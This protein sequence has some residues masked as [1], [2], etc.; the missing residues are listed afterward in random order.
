MVGG[1][2]HKRFL[3]AALA[4]HF[5]LRNV[6]FC[7]SFTA[8]RVASTLTTRIGRRKNAY[9]SPRS[10]S[11]G[12]TYPR[13]SSASSTALE[14]LPPIEQVVELDLVARGL[15]YVVGAGSLVL[16]TPIAVRL[17]RQGTA[18][19]LTMSTWWLKLVSYTCSDI[20]AFTNGYPVSTYVETLVITTEA[21]VVLYLT[22]HYQR[23]VNS[24]FMSFVALY[25]LGTAWGVTV[26]PSSIVALGQ[27]GAAILNTGALVPQFML[28]YETKSSGDYSPLTAGLASIGCFIRI[29]TTIQLADSDPILLGTFGLAFVLNT[30]LAAQILWF[31]VVSEG[32]DLKSLLTA[33][34]SSSSDIT[35]IENLEDET[36]RNEHEMLVTSKDVKA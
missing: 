5:L 8:S 22:A 19:G 1:N 9:Q 31:G 16:Y 15:G 33:D 26:A 25:V 28:N 18:D 2:L 13:P 3:S 4:L 24:R 32:R 36:N 30:A 10:D 14:S 12:T 17:I 23:R 29:F 35:D 11:A 20:Y 21:A 34:F 6:L 7:D 27:G